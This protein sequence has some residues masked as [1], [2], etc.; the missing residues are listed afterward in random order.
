M[1]L[2]TK[3]QR[4]NQFKNETV[5]SGDCTSAGSAANLPA[6]GVRRSTSSIIIII[7]LTWLE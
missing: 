1:Q 3:I 4:E 5:D 6:S 7:I 2:N